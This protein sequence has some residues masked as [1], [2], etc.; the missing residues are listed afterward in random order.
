MVQAVTLR[1]IRNL[2]FLMLEC[3]WCSCLLLEVLMHIMLH[4][5]EWICT[6]FNFG[7][8]MFLENLPWFSSRI[9]TP[10]DVGAWP[11]DIQ[12]K[13]LLSS[14]SWLLRVQQ[15]LL[16]G[17]VEQPVK[18][19]PSGEIQK[20]HMRFPGTLTF[21]VLLERPEE[22]S[23]RGS[24]WRPA[25]LLCRYVDDSNVELPYRWWF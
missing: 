3:F 23:W 13:A 18:P 15:R 20:R 22:S 8:R 12:Q 5:I 4:N 7:L 10:G 19:Q 21:I 11:S 1:N 2:F 14:G 9:L 16:R 25:A 17:E 6:V 24:A